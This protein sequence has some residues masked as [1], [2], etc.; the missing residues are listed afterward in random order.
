[1]PELDAIIIGSGPAGLE[2]ALNLKIRKK[3]FL[4]FGSES[5]SPKLE[6]A[7]R[8]DN[9]LGFPGITGMELKSKMAAHLKAMDIKITPERVSAVYPMGKSFSVATNKNIYESR[10]VILACGVLENSELP[11]EKAFLG[12]GVGYCATCDAPLYKGKTVAI[13]GYGGDAVEEANFVSEIAAKVFFFPLGKKMKT[14]LSGGIEIIDGEPA[15]ITGSLKAETLTIDNGREL[16]AD[17]FFIL[18]DSIAPQSLIP[19]LETEHGYVSADSG[20]RT[21]IEGCFAAGDCTGKPHQYMRAAGQGQTAA[22]S[23][24]KYLDRIKES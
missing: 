4:L 6:A 24:V 7:P 19:G 16:K 15:A 11:G 2:A 14:A 23:A 21:N 9:Y 20:M 10:V 17:G 22:L 13:L 3:N 5:L 12:R 18:R 8:I 1:M